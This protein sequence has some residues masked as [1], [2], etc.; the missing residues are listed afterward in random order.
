MMTQ[1]P[2]EFLINT[3]GKP[4]PE[5]PTF[6]HTGDEIYGNTA[7]SQ[8]KIRIFYIRKKNT[9]EAFHTDH[10][11]ASNRITWFF[12]SAECSPFYKSV[13]GNLNLSDQ[14]DSLA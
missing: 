10:Y 6:P 13:N 14:F 11:R 8:A 3:F 4:F 9:R 12:I 5:F 1:N 7:E 2:L